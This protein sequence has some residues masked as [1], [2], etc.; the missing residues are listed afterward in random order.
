M[1]PASL[2]TKACAA[3]AP[4]WGLTRSIM[5]NEGKCICILPEDRAETA[6]AAMRPFALWAGGRSRRYGDCRQSPG[7]PDHPHRGPPPVGHAGR[8]ATAPHLLNPLTLQTAP[9]TLGGQPAGFMGY[10][11]ERSIAIR[12]GNACPEKR[13]VTP[14]HWEAPNGASRR[15]ISGPKRRA[16]KSGKICIYWHRCRIAAKGAPTAERP[17]HP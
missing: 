10:L 7:D 3:A 14:R 2:F 16:L 12:R 17:P 13:S 15:G 11:K 1:K 5:A 9:V 6:L 4:S 8:R